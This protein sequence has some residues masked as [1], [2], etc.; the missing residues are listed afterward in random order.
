[1]RDGIGGGGI[2]APTATGSP[3]EGVPG[4][5]PTEARPDNRDDEIGGDDASGRDEEIGHME[6]CGIYPM[7]E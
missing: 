4:Q 2:G 1:V 5:G 3:P 6:Q 7:A